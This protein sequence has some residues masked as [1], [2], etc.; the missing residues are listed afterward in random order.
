VDLMVTHPTTPDGVE[1][2]E[3][4][5]DDPEHGLFAFD[6]DGTLAPI[7]ADPATAVAHPDAVDALSD[8]ASAGVSVVVITGRPAGVALRL[9]GFDRPGLERLTIAGHY[10]A[11][12][13]DGATGVLSEAPA[14]PGLETAR[15]R[16]P[17][18]VDALDMP[19]I[20]I[21]EKGIALAVHTRN[22]SDPDRAERYLLPAL[23][24]LAEV[25]ELA[26]EPGRHVIELRPV[27][28]D[29]GVALRGFV[30][31]R[32]VRSVVVF[33]DDMG[34][35]A[36]FDAA[37]VLRAEGTYALLV[38]SG[39]DEVPEIAERADIVVD[40]PDGVVELVRELTAAIRSRSAR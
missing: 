37:E 5:L 36:A 33:G 16:V 2:L 32:D 6:Y 24:A 7:T 39:S 20:E 31:E 1:A 9:G 25:A 10:G 40:G 14:P 21:E 13:W 4:L 3:A 17:R 22:A 18:I 35:I 29:K 11:E 19:G 8:L 26:V 28:V 30:T 38:C 12:R 23:S 34:D 27:G 15:T